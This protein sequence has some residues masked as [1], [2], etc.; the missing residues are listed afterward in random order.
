MPVPEPLAL[1]QD[2]SDHRRLVSYEAARIRLPFQHQGGRVP[3]Q[4]RVLLD[5]IG[6]RT[7]NDDRSWVLPVAEVPET[8]P[9][10][11][12]MAPPPPVNASPNSLPPKLLAL[13]NLGGIGL[14]IGGYF[15]LKSLMELA[16]T[17]SNTTAMP[18]SAQAPTLALLSVPTITLAS[19][20]PRKISNTL[21][22]LLLLL[23]Y[24][25]PAPVGKKF[26]HRQD[27]GLLVTSV[28]LG[29]EAALR[30]KRFALYAMTGALLGSQ[31]LIANVV[32]WL[33]Y[34]NFNPLWKE[35]FR[36]N[37]ILGNR[38]LELA[39]FDPQSHVWQQFSNYL[40]LDN[41]DN[42]IERFIELLNETTAPPA[43]EGPPAKLEHRK[44][45]PLGPTAYAPAPLNR[46]ISYID[47]NYYRQQHAPQ[48]SSPLLTPTNPHK[49]FRKHELHQNY[50]LPHAKANRLNLMENI[51]VKKDLR[52]SGIFNMVRG[53]LSSKDHLFSTT[54]LSTN[55][56]NYTVQQP[57]PK[58]VEVR[59]GAL[60]LPIRRLLELE[61]LPFDSTPR[62]PPPPPPPPP[63]DAVPPPP[64]PSVP[65]PPKPTL[66]PPVPPP[67]PS[68]PPPS[69][70]AEHGV[71]PLPLEAPPSPPKPPSAG[72]ISSPRGDRILD[73]KY[74]PKKDLM[75]HHSKVILVSRDNLTFVP[76][77][78]P[79]DELHLGPMIKELIS[80]ALQLPLAPFTVH[81]T[82]FYAREGNAL[83]EP[84][85]LE[86]VRGMN[87]VKFLV[88]LEA[89]LPSVN[90]YLTNSLDL[91]LFEIKGDND[92]IYPATPQ[93]LLQRPQE[94]P[95]TDYWNCKD[96]LETGA[97]V[98]LPPEPPKAHYFPLRLPVPTATPGASSTPKKAAEPPNLQINTQDPPQSRSLPPSSTLPPLL[99]TSQ[100]ALFRV[101]RRE[102]G[103]EIDFDKRRKSLVE[104]KAPKLIPNIYTS[105]LQTDLIR[106]PVLALTIQTAK[107]D[108]NKLPLVPTPDQPR[109]PLLPDVKLTLPQPMS[110]NV[111]RLVSSLRSGLRPGLRNLELRRQG[112]TG[113]AIIAKRLAP[114][115]PDRQLLVLRL[116]RVLMLRQLLLNRIPILR[117]ASRRLELFSFKENLI[118]FADAPAFSD[119]GSDDFFAKPLDSQLSD[120]DFFAKPMPQQKQQQRAAS[121]GDFFAKPMK[122][123]PPPPPPTAGN[124]DEFFMKRMPAKPKPNMNLLRPPAEE[125]F[126]NLEKYFPNTNLDKPII[127]E[128]RV[129][130][131][132]KHQ[133]QGIAKTFSS[134]NL[135]LPQALTV[136]NDDGDVYYNTAIEN[137]PMRRMKTIRGVAIEARTRLLAGKR[138]P[139]VPHSVDN[140]AENLWVLT[141]PPQFNLGRLKT[142]MW[143]QRVTEVTL[144]EIER[145]VVLNI[146]GKNGLFDRFVW[147]KG[148]LI[149]RGSFGCV[150]LGFNVTTGEMLAVKQVEA[151]VD[152]RS[153]T[154]LNHGGI[155][156]LHKEVET[157]K[158]LVHDNIVQYLG[159]EQKGNLY[160]MFL[161]YVSG[162]LVLAILKQFGKFDEGLIRHIT[163]QVLMGLQYIHSNGILHRDMKADNLLLEVDG[164]CKI[165]DFGIS[166]RS[167][168]IYSNNAEMSMQGTV[169][170]M[171]P[172]V[173]DSIV[174]DKKQGYLAKVD[175]WSLGC[176]L[177]EMYAG[178]RPWLNE[179]V[180][181]AIYKIGK[182]KLA[183]PI[184]G[185]IEISQEAREFIAACFT[186]DPNL[187]PTALELLKH[188]FMAEDPSF[189]FADTRLAKEILQATRKK[190]LVRQ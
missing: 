76:V 37:A 153:K 66:V 161:E 68:I 48:N 189:R 62:K 187:R 167:K 24:A 164:T 119:S 77:A 9:D 140:L 65:P 129:D 73:E 183:P 184:P 8:Y 118:S 25:Q 38:F 179:A 139:P 159:Y 169:F 14:I 72:V 55:V 78:V 111:T 99:T 170:W 69:L 42:L 112:L 89:G 26:H 171:A 52:K 132:A 58:L 101:I 74:W 120:T 115:P 166:K 130:D 35:A 90:T 60:P 85:L 113:S 75:F 149:G 6:R 106:L 23:D 182:T 110:G 13:S 18:A 155:M 27:L 174:E 121:D 30:D 157:M 122:K 12:I 147:I 33:D 91:R 104:A 70:F 41:G 172:E 116:L 31:W 22:K 143:G 141:P 17:A 10:P 151:Q 63:A 11:L 16:P 84:V 148:E 88:K 5:P 168:D 188:P 158:D 154:M 4:L 56:A 19:D 43:E 59:R 80:K 114:P 44:L 64:V 29:T 160:N 34:N 173:I 175:I 108:G 180:V 103:R 87:L 144:S 3:E 40:E 190:G 135:P 176:V 36:R 162:G 186:I 145:G 1:P 128:R 137:K 152:H 109:A 185:N 39:N 102:E 46:P 150:Y 97:S 134:A 98:Q 133:A 47:P 100:P 165:S 156:A 96:P 7:L 79:P 81:L 2:Y 57:V 28:G 117:L 163:R 71:P 107:E 177:L 131:D 136:P 146:Q 61:I 138:A 124:D 21:T 45:T 82:D 126:D 32:R 86:V 50:I 67:V 53:K 181:S 95:V 127:E 54:H 15:G 142:K 83:P 125:V 178:H 92:K 123:P 94:A 51:S 93:Y 49:F 20:Q 105:S